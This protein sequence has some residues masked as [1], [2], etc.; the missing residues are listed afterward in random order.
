MADNPTST[1]AGTPALFNDQPLKFGI[2]CI[3]VTGGNF[4]S[5][6][7][8]GFEATWDQNLQIA[9]LADQIGFECIVPIARW[10]G[11]DGFHDEQ[12]ETL[13]YAAGLGAATENLMVFAT[14]ILPT[15]HP[16]YAAKAIA[17][18]DQITHGRAGLNMVMGWNAQELAMFGITVKDHSARYAYGHEW[19]TIVQK[20]WTEDEPFDFT[21]DHFDVKGGFSRPKP[22]QARPVTINAGGSPAA[23]DFAA[24]H[25]DFNFVN[26]T[27]EE[28]SREYIET[29]RTL[30]REKYNRSIGMITTAVI[31]ARDTEEEAQTAYR[32]LIDNVKWAT[33][34]RFNAALGINIEGSYAVHEDDEQRSQ[35]ARFAAA[36]GTPILVGTPEQIVDG[37]ESVKNAGVDCTFLAM[38]DYVD[39][40][41]YFEE[42]VLPLLKKRG[43]RH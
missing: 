43:L 38:I 13:T 41:P 15:L 26:F 35:L 12:L 2:F 31:I 32:D 6:V 14:L 40:L 30:A 5:D 42:R 33:A 4:C 23:Q 18:I 17:T 37:L 25:A 27:T 39:E 1:S 34:E 9:K 28:E 11:F 36:G 7:K 19:S 20:L 8:T 24:K 16:T 22:V 3:N 21:G 29:V 10:R